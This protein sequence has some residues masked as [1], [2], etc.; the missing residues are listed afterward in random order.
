[1]N[2][3]R[4]SSGI[5]VGTFTQSGTTTTTTS[6][7]YSVTLDEAVPRPKRLNRRDRRKLASLRRSG[8]R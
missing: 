2:P 1:M 5:I 8:A 6:G 7:P 4:D 3:K